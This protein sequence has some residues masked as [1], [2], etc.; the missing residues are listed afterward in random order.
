MFRFRKQKH[1]TVPSIFVLKTPFYIIDMIGYQITWKTL[2]IMDLCRITGY[3][4][5][6]HGKT[7]S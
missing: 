2:F 3:V 4:M 6:L 7:F 5:K 1:I